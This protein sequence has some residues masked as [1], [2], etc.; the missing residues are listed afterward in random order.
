VNR[1][2]K[3]VKRIDLAY[4]F[5]PET[6]VLQGDLAYGANHDDLI[7]LDVSDPLNPQRVASLVPGSSLG[8]KRN[9]LDVVVDGH[10]AYLA[11]NG[12][13]VVDISDPSSPKELYMYDIDTRAVDIGINENHVY[14]AGLEDGLLIFDVSDPSQPKLV[15]QV[16]IS[17]AGWRGD[18]VDA[19]DFVEQYACVVREMDNT[20]FVEILDVSNPTSPRNGSV[21]TPKPRHGPMDIVVQDHYAYLNGLFYSIDIADLSDPL[22]PRLVGSVETPGQVGQYV[23]DRGYVYIADS[24]NIS[25]IDTST[26]AK[27]KVVG[28]YDMITVSNVAKVGDY[29]YAVG[30]TAGRAPELHIFQFE[31]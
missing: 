10:Y 16:G 18:G 8:K 27:P 24:F 6:I 26:P 12:L 28:F 22:V 13:V 21:Y 15:N 5:S 19:V 23:V 25:I 7:I 20:R 11:A 2:I 29:L 30:Q 9:V 3:L 4:P 1:N 17:D 31:P 14:L